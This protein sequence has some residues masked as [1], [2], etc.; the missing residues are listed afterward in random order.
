LLD[1]L[2]SE[3][4]KDWDTKRLVKLMLTSAAFRRDARASAAD[5]AKDPENRLL[6]RGPRLRLD[7]EQLRDN[8]LFV[9]GLMNFEMGGRGVNVYQPPGIWEPVGYADSNTRYYLQDHGAALYRRSIYVFIK[10]TA[11]APFLTNF[12]ATNREQLCA[13]RDRT[14]T[15][16]QALQLMNDVQHFEAARALAE[17]TIF[18]A[19]KGT[20][21]RVAFLYRTVLGRKPDADE[22][23]IVTA[24]LAKQRAIFDA[25]PAA[26]K[27]VV[28]V[29]ESKPKG[30][31]PDAEV[32][33]WA[34]IANLVLNL[35]EVVMRN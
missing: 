7:A 31:A 28:H 20:P 19:G 16:L 29:G 17:R 8:A 35:D 14:N 15:P 2:A 23:R 1:W 34:L 12:D 24:A 3:Y 11:P 26:A 32:A 22:V 25:D 10:R 13:V 9:S 21:E 6:A 4:Q 30:A 27:K 5:R 33:A 18:E